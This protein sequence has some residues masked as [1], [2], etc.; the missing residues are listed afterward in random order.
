MFKPQHVVQAELKPFLRRNV[1][2]EVLRVQ[3]M[4]NAYHVTL[5]FWFQAEKENTRYYFSSG[6][7]WHYSAF[8][9]IFGGRK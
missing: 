4:G 9:L 5:G 8:R 6:K 1:N 2:L 7:N 3:S